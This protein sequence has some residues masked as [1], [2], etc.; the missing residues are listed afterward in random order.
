[1]GSIFLTLSMVTITISIRKRRADR[2]RRLAR[3]QV[4]SWLFARAARDDPDWAT[5]ISSLSPTERRQLADLVEHYLRTLR[6]SGRESFLA[7]ATALEM[8]ATATEGLDHPSVLTR[9]Q[10]LARL[11]LLEYPIDEHRLLEN[12]LEHRRTR[13]AAAR[14]LAERRDE[15]SN[16]EALGTALLIWDGQQPMGVRGL[17]TLYELNETDPNPLF[18]QGFWAVHRW[19]PTVVVQVCTVLQACRIQRMQPAHEWV[20]TLFD[21]WNPRI[22]AAAIRAVMGAGHRD[23]IRSRIPFSHLVTD[24]DPGVRRSTYQV[25]AAWGDSRSRGLLEWAVIDEDDERAQLVA[26][27]ALASIEGE[28]DAEQPGWPTAAWNW[29]RAERAVDDSRP[30]TTAGVTT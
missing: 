27:R 24:E 6:G 15:F 22:R 30:V 12:S 25:L 19:R 9:L 18:T 17:D 21:H 10:A 5:W 14:L 1:M 29:V 8:G 4:R 3:E 7:V 16:P 2:R 28:P 20:F 26:I 11:T 13:E 23:D